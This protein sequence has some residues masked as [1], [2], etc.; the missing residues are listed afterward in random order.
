MNWQKF[1]T[2]IAAAARQ[3]FS[4]LLARHGDETFYAFALEVSDDC[5]AMKASANSLEQHRAK[6]ARE[7]DC[8]PQTLI[9]Y[10][11]AND[12]WAYDA[13]AASPFNAI[14]KQL[15][16]P[17]NR[18]DKDEAG[19]EAFRRHVHQ[20]MID[21]LKMLDTEGFF[22]PRRHKAVLFIT[23]FG[24]DELRALEDHSARLLNPP[25]IHEPFLRRYEK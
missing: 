12:E 16:D 6:A 11:W 14:S 15:S 2:D 17:R 8:D 20:A 3:S 13:F 24:Y 18:D 22:G 1:T 21:A 5:Y 25:E 7:S 4:E 9:Y 23:S 19:F 10:Q